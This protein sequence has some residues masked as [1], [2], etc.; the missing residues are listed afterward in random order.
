MHITPVLPIDIKGNIDD[1]LLCLAEQVC[2]QSATLTGNHNPIVLKSIQD[3]LRTTN[4]YYSNKIESEGTHPI[5][6]EKAMKKNFSTDEK[7]RKLQFL[8]LAYIETQ[9]QLENIAATKMN[10]FTKDFIQSIHKTFY[11]QAEMETFLTIK[12]KEQSVVMKPGE[13]RTQNVYVGNHIAPEYSLLNTIINEFENQYKSVYYAQTQ[14]KKLLYLLSSHH[15]LTWIHP[16]LDGNGRVSRLFLD[17][18]FFNLKIAGY[19]LWNIA[20]GLARNSQ[21]YQK[22]L[23]LADMPQQGATDGRGPLS[24]RGLKYYLDYMLS[25]ALDQIDFMNKN[26]QLSSLANRIDKFIVLANNGMID[27]EPFPKYTSLLLKELLIKGEVARGEVKDII[28][29]SDRTATSLIKTLVDRD[30]VESDTPKSA[31]RIKFNAKFASYL[32]PNLI[33]EQ[34]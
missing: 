32:M 24:L 3:L 9:K 15:R 4:S 28:H 26:L 6:I 10:I 2:I 17:A 31:I 22:H 7:K 27:I 13:L 30:Y 19:G 25:T 34:T 29:K 12:Q 8:S 1:E 21:E 18:G 20:R 33:P 23:A 11:S 5:D 16:F 14:A